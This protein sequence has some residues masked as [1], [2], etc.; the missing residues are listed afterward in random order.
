MDKK[1]IMHLFEDNE[2]NISVLYA[3]YAKHIPGKQSFWDGISKEEIAHAS[4]VRKAAEEMGGWDIIGENK[5]T[6]GVV[7]NVMDFV[8]EEI[9]K[10]QKGNISH[11]E[12]LRT[13]LRIE[14]SM[15]EKKCFDIF[16]PANVTIKKMLDRLNGD[17]ERHVAMLL[18]EMKKSKLTLEK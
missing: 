14:R 4:E 8:M 2:L 7:K 12:A 18:N 5:F 1:T 15:L 11:S 16:I 6:R 10:A 3:L 9:K 13:A 17:T